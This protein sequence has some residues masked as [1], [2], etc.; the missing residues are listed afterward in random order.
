MRAAAVEERAPRLLNQFRHLRGHGRDRQRADLDAARI[1]EVADEAPHPVGLLVDDPE[2]LV[3]LG[4]VERRRGGQHRG[5]RALDGGER[6]AQLVAHHAQELRAQAVQLLQRSKVLHGDHQRGHRAVLAGDRRRVDQ[7]RDAPPAGRR[8]Q[9]FLGAHRVGRLHHLGQREPV[10]GNLAPV[11]QP[12]G[13]VR[14]QSPGGEVRRAQGVD[15]PQRLPVGRHRTPGAG[16][17]DH[18]ADRSGLDQRL[19][20]G[21]RAPLLLVGAGIHDR[22][23]RLRGEQL[24]HLVVR[25]GEVGRILLAGQEEV[26]DLHA[27]AAHGRAVQRPGAH[28]LVGESEG[29][30]VVRQIVEPERARQI[31]Q[32]GE[33]PCPVGPLGELAVLVRVK[34]GGDELA[35]LARLVDG[36]DE[37]VARAGELAGAV[38]GLLQHGGELKAGAKAQ[39][40]R[41]QR[42]DALAQDLD[43]AL[44]LLAALQWTLPVGGQRPGPCGAMSDR[45]PLRNPHDSPYCAH[46][47]LIV[48]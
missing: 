21:P 26:A 31:A 47:H 1:E 13:H 33:Q 23:R 17:D 8:Q 36:D 34:A 19:E 5:R 24:Q 38:G 12:A 7:H 42:G 4:R 37:A 39:H 11:A 48:T 28:H 27:A 9:D 14:R 18:H 44:Q 46:N 29:A 45:R 22:R 35:H 10:E 3:Q 15:E 32:I 41:A 30:E 40:R 20:V 2:E 25:V 16:V 43:L 6:R